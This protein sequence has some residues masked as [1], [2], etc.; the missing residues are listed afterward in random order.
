MRIRERVGIEASG[1]WLGIVG[2]LL[3]GLS[4]L[5][6]VRS[7]ALALSR[8]QVLFVWLG[9]LSLLALGGL[10]L[11]TNTLPYPLTWEQIAP[12]VRAVAAALAGAVVFTLVGIA[13]MRLGDTP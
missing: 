12:V 3:F 6:P 13:W 5:K 11:K 4:V 1:S 7:R 8:G 10:A 2:F 9:G